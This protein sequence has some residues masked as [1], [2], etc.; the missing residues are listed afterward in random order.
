[1]KL[2]K[3]HYLSIGIIIIIGIA[4]NFVA[5]N[6]DK[7]KIKENYKGYIIYFIVESTFNSLYVFYKFIMVKKFIKSDVI[8]FF[9][10]LI[11]LL[12]EIITLVI[13]TKYFKNFDNFFLYRNEDLNKSEIFFF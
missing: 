8:L 13:T 10:G 5:G 2:Y 7:N 1:M 9:Q 4:D 3:H 6:F 12:L 11:E